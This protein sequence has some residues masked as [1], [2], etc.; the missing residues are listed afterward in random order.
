MQ[1]FETDLVRLS[2]VDICIKRIYEKPVRRDGYR[3]LVDRL[4]PRGI[5]KRVRPSTNGCAISHP[6]PNCGNGSR[7]NRDAGPHSVTDT[8]LRSALRATPA[9]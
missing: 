6:L 9:S 7:T 5:K 3:I 4:W 1:G 8:L 2:D